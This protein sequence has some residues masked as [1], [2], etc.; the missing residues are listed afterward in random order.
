[1]QINDLKEYN[2]LLRHGVKEEFTAWFWT[3]G[4]DV[5]NSGVWTHAYDGSDV[6]FFAP[7]VS[8]GCSQCTNSDLG[9]A[10]MV[11][12]GA[13]DPQFRGNYCDHPS[14]AAKTFICEA[15]I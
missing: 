13:D 4:N 12:L 1:M 14:S 8:C 9:D 6:S 15:I 5:T 10:F 11:R 3:D 2:C 7:R